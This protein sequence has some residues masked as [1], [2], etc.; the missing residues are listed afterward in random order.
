MCRSCRVEVALLTTKPLD[1]ESLSVC[2]R[3]VKLGLG[4]MLFVRDLSADEESFFGAFSSVSVGLSTLTSG[5]IGRLPFACIVGAVGVVS[6]IPTGID[7]TLILL[8]PFVMANG[9]SSSSSSTGLVFGSMGT[10]TFSLCL[11]AALL[12]APALIFGEA[13]ISSSRLVLDPAALAGRE[14]GIRGRG[15][16]L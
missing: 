8:R 13:I 9:R 11:L 4:E 10:K 15:S 14:L 12:N 3:R 6:T 1:D 7:T 16:E 2:L 5:W